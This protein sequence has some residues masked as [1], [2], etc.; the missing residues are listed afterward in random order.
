MGI[1][2]MVKTGYAYRGPF[3]L[4]NTTLMILPPEGE[5]YGFP[6]TCPSNWGLWEK[7]RQDEWLVSQGYPKSLITKTFS[8]SLVHIEND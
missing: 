4:T 6:I 5:K 8:I 7:E 3:N 2:W 1:V